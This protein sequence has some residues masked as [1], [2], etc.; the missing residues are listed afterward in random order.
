MRDRGLDAKILGLP[1]PW[2]VEDVEER[3]DARE[4]IVTVGLRR[5][6]ELACRDCGEAMD[7]HDHRRRRWRHLDN[8]ITASTRPSS[9]LRFHAGECPT[10]GV[11]Q[12]EVPWGEERSRF[13]ALFEALASDWLRETSES[14]VV[15][16]KL[17]RG[18]GAR[19][20]GP[21]RGAGLG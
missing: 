11:R 2:H 15:R 9:W 6:L 19:H 21:G 14:A 3:E 1:A 7:G 18:R 12:I 4:V 10:H 5:P 8:W 17:T 20:H 13:T 16:R